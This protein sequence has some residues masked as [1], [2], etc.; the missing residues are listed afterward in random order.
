[1]AIQNLG[2]K[3]TSGLMWT[4][5]ERVCAQGVSALVTVILARILMPEDYGVVSI[6]AIFITICDTLVV[7]GFSDTLIQKPD[8][9][10]IDFSTMFW[11][12]LVIGIA[13]YG[14][15]FVSA[16][17]I[18]E[19]FH[20]SL[21][22]ATLR[23]MAIRMPINAINSIQSAYISKHMKYK[24][25]FFATLIGTVISAA[26][27][28]AMAYMGFG[29]WALVA[30]YLTNSVI[31]TFVLW[32][33][34]GWRASFVFRLDR[35]KKMYSFG[36]KMQL[37]SLLATL[38]SEIESFCIG[39]KY[40]SV[41]LAYYDKGRQFP[42]LIMHNVQ[43]SIG[44]VMLPAFSHISSDKEKM[45]NMARRSVKVSTFVM[46]PLLIGLILCADEFVSAVLTDKWMPAVPFLRLLSIYYLCAPLMSLNKQIVIASG[47]AK[48][49][50]I[51]EIE[52]KCIGISLL[53]IALL[54]FDTVLA[55][56]VAAVL[57]QLIGL[58]IQSLPLK[59]LINYPIKEQIKD[60]FPSFLQS[61]FMIIP[62]IIIK[63]M[64]LNV[65]LMLIFEVII[66]A[67]FYIGCSVVTKNDAF[68]TGL[69]ILKKFTGKKKVR[70]L[71]K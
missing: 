54:A 64:T 10:A 36:W 44:K 12:V 49:Y 21:V 26:V 17:F 43:T 19:F 34:C 62:I 66:S 29:V 28:I 46:F 33:T 13:M 41:D 11:F 67:L 30:Q 32:L 15:I 71:D 7:G 35:L 22:A 16:P 6:V 58:I 18:E 9:D 27:G 24:Y 1:M 45:K 31:D 56:A 61:V 5:L 48:K 59:R 52:K 14:V 63:Q 25:F 40:S 20:T 4:Y 65:W 55:I 37:S 70:G 42:K 8:S 47:E 50:L 60:V 3:I 68:L 23:V 53:L 69:E 57:T 2:K 39:K 51:M 38:Y